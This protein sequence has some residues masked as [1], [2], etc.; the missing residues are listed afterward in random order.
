MDILN[1]DRTADIFKLN[2]LFDEDYFK[3]LFFVPY[4]LLTVTD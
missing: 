3:C 4:N 2:V 1:A